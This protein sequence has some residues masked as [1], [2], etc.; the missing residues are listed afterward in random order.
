VVSFAGLAALKLF[1]WQDRKTTD[2]DALDFYRVLST[3]ADAGNLDRLYGEEIRLLEQA[4]YDLEL[5]G[6]ALLAHDV[7]QLASAATQAHPI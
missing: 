6:A 4:C 5:A 2:K 7:K 1:A 3:Y